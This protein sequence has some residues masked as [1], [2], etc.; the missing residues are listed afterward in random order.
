MTSARDRER[1]SALMAGLA[2][3]AAAWTFIA[4]F[5]PQTL[6][7]LGGYSPWFY[8]P[9]STA[10]WALFSGIAYLFLRGNC[11]SATSP[12][13]IANYRCRELDNLLRSAG[14]SVCASREE[15]RRLAGITAGLALT[16][17]LWVAALSFLPE[18]WLDFLSAA[19]VWFYC[20][21]SAGLWGILS[22]VM[23]LALRA[24]DHRLHP[25][26]I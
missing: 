10:V 22:T 23:Y 13:T 15:R 18:N 17:S 2:A 3:M 26:K 25:S 5:A 24:P 20:L 1:F 4:A 14:V 19:P 12:D 7:S 11:R 21:T 16:I 9:V 6:E 8:G